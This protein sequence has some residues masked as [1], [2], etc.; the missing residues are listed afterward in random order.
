MEHSETKKQRGENYGEVG[1]WS[2]VD[3]YAIRS[4]VCCWS[5]G[6]VQFSCH[7]L[8]FEKS[9]K[10]DIDKYMVFVDTGVML[11]DAVS[12]VEDVAEKQC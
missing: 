9:E 3:S 1:S 12:F 6:V 5:S 4:L 7:S 2:F 8:Y 10:L 11:S